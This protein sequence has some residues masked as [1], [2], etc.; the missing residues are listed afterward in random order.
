VNSLK[1]EKKSRK[2]RKK[3]RK[4]KKGKKSRNKRRA[5]SQPKLRVLAPKTNNAKFTDSHHIISLLKIN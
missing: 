1:S 2:T 4:R 5:T 3:K